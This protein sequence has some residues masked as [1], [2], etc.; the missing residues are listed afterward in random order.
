MSTSANHVI[1]PLMLLPSQL[2]RRPA[3]ARSPEM[4]LVV[5]MFDDAIQSASRNPNVCTRRQYQDYLDARAWLRDDDRE[6]PFAFRN[7]CD[8]LDLD[9]QAVRAH[10]LR[11]NPD[12]RRLRKAS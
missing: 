2:P 1:Q 3:S 6:W 11:T 9:A 8:L 12:L 10:V 7:V 4:C 5:A